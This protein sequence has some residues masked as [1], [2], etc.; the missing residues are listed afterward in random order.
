MAQNGGRDANQSDRSSPASTPTARQIEVS[1]PATLIS[2]IFRLRGR[3][4]NHGD[5][6]LSTAFRERLGGL[7][8]PVIALRLAAA[9]GKITLS[10]PRVLFLKHY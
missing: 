9:Q 3:H 4:A 10:P 8:P 5:P 2:L 7:L 1:S 6:G